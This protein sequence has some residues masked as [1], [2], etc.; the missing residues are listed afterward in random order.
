[1]PDLK[2]KKKP[3]TILWKSL[4]VLFD[5]RGKNGKVW[6]AGTGR[7]AHKAQA[8]AL[9]VQISSPA[10]GCVEEGAGRTSQGEG[11]AWLRLR[12]RGGS[13]GRCVKQEAGV[14]GTR[15]GAVGEEAGREL[16]P[17]WDSQHL[18]FLPCHQAVN[19]YSLP[20]IR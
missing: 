8:W 15:R 14:Q 2:K 1:M 5:G 16:K 3:P 12:L 19:I 17:D 7:Q 4:W 9:C 10:T 13:W 11:A 20:Y 6:R 18:Q